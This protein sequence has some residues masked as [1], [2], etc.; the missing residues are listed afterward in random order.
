MKKVLGIMMALLVSLLFTGCGES[1]PVE[2]DNVKAVYYINKDETK[3]EMHEYAVQAEDTQGQLEELIEQLQTMPAKLEYKAPLQ[4]GF[5]LLSYYVEGE[6]L[7][8]DVSEA[9][10]SLKPTTEI[11]VR[12]ALVRTFTQAEGIK[13]ITMT[14]EGNQLHD[15]LGSVVGLMSADQFIDNAGD[16]INTYEWVRL[17]LYFASEDGTSLIATNRKMA[18]STNISVEKLVVEQLIAGP[19]STVADVVY[20]TVNPLTKVISIVVKD[21]VCYANFDETFLTQIYNVSSE[22][23]IYS[24]VNSLTEITGV[25]KVQ[26]SINGETDIMYRETISLNTIFERNLDLVTTVE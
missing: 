5:E 8:L 24:V 1:A 20:P 26:I 10:R 2:G 15:S 19:T 17:K 23:A 11:L 7:Y 21:G 16:E 3:V 6:K 22:V 14:V 9:Y 18:Y 12:A 4:M 25:N 13:Y